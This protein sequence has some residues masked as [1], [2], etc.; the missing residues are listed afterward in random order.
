MLKK[1]RVAV[2]ISG[3]GSNMRA[4]I[5]ACKNND[6]PAEIVLVLSNKAS[7]L[8]LEYAKQNNIDTLVV[9]NKNFSNREDFDK[10]LDEEISKH[11]IDII[12]LAG[13]MRLLT[14]W[15]V[16]KWHDKVIN[17]HPSFLPH[18]KGANA[19]EDAI[20]AKAEYSGC[21]VHYVRAEMDS[22]PIIK[23]V[24]VDILP[25]DNK[26]TLASRILEQEH[27]IY[28]EALKIVALNY[29]DNKNNK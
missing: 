21:T 4:L 22:G 8:G 9:E 15:F 26:E 5:E 20:S 16:E 10:K 24:R 25:N 17:I 14:P 1:V 19:V 28:P 7:A 27:K 6:F 2:L 11:N 29:I 23:Q 13:F 3:R 12:C 18:F